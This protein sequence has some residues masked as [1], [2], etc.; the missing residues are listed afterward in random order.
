MKQYHLPY[1]IKVVGKDL[2]WEE[3][4]GTEFSG[5]KY[6]SKKNGDEEEYKFKTRIY[7]LESKF[8]E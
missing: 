7:I 3:V 5:R 4:K 1:N 2:I 6:R 8:L